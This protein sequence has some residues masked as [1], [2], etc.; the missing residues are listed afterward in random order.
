[1]HLP[2]LPNR[3]KLSTQIYTIAVQLNL[4]RQKIALHDKWPPYLLVQFVSSLD[5]QYL[6][7]EPQ[8]GTNLLD[9]QLLLKPAFLFSPL[10]AFGW[11]AILLVFKF[12]Q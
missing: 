11:M 3:E 4:N 10:A 1:M 6:W 12:L 5:Q 8:T 7:L 9:L 2:V